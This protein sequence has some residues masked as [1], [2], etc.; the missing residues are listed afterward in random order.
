MTAETFKRNASTK[1]RRETEFFS[2]KD[3]KISISFNS[4][5]RDNYQEGATKIYTWVLAHQTDI[6]HNNSFHHFVTVRFLS[7]KF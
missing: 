1:E 4:M 2:S 3:T 5:L 6:V 7:D